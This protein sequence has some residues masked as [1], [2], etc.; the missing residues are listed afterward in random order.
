MTKN[1]DDDES[2]VSIKKLEPTMTKTRNEL[3]E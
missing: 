2:K 1:W 3:K